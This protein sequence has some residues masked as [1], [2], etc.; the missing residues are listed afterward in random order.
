MEL[1][2]LVTIIT[3]AALESPLLK[4]LE[5]LGARGYTIMEARGKGA[6]GARTADWDQNLNVQIEV[7][8]DGSVAAA[9]AE[10]C[11]TSYSPNYAMVV[12]VSDVQVLRP[13]KF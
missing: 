11:R 4:D 6:R 10:H 7:I 8:C 9:I 2:K 12:Y 13:E 5:R 1:R 3:E